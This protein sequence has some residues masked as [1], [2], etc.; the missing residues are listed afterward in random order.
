MVGFSRPSNTT[1]ETPR[2]R[3]E[4]LAATHIDK[5]WKSITDSIDELREWLPWAVQA[6]EE[7]TRA[8]ATTCE[9]DW[10]ENRSWT[11]VIL[12]RGEA[13][14]TI[15]LADSEP[16]TKPRRTR[17]LDAIGRCGQRDT[18]LRLRQR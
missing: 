6:T 9:A 3:L 11:F 5:L 2:L 17:L 8:F 14:G 12:R 1:I 13:I 15:G 18:C 7:E 4:P 10:I 16:Q